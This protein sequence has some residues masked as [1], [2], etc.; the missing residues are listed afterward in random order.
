MKRIMIFPV[1]LMAV[2]AVFPQ[3][4]KRKSLYFIAPMF[5]TSFITHTNEHKA[6][7]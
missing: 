7:A 4:D 5:L 6:G 3:V 1:V 2:A